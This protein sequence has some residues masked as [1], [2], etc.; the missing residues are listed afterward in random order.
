MLNK[1]NEKITKKQKLPFANS[2]ITYYYLRQ[3]GLVTEI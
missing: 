2:T 3:V 1:S